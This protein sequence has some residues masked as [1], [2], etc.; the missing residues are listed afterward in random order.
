[1]GETGEWLGV[2]V[3]S[4]SVTLTGIAS[5]PVRRRLCLRGRWFSKGASARMNALSIPSMP[6]SWRGVCGYSVSAGSAPSKSYPVNHR[7]ANHATAAAL[8]SFLDP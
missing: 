7:E 6:S 8:C 2:L 3:E 4:Q 5:S 1:M